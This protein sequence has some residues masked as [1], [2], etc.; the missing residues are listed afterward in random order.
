M[1]NNQ[2]IIGGK[3]ENQNTYNNIL[4]KINEYIILNE[5]DLLF[6]KTLTKEQLLTIIETNNIYTELMNNYVMYDIKEC[7]KSNK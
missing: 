7:K 6:I 4:C 3:N 2:I 5:D 1:N